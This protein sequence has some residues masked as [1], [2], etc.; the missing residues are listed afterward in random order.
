MPRFIE[1]A[2][3]LLWKKG[4]SLGVPEQE[5]EESRILKFEDFNRSVELSICKLSLDSMVF[6]SVA[7]ILLA[8]LV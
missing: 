5:I 8:E 1:L 7:V 6:S 2:T 4:R 3:Y